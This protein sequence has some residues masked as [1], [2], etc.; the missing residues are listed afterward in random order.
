MSNRRRAI[1]GRLAAALWVLAQPALVLA[2]DAGHGGE[3]H[4]PSIADLTFPV[5]NFTIYLFIVFKYLVPALR[6]Y[7]R[8]RREDV[9]QLV[10][11]A[12][13]SLDEAKRALADARQALAAIATETTAIKSDIV[14][15]AETAAT[16]LRAQAEETGRRRV[17]DAQLLAEQERRRAIAELRAEIATLA[18]ATAEERIRGALSPNDHRAFVEQFLAEA[19]A[20]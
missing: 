16:R 19:P 13:A 20:R 3:H 10:A 11:G 4:V 9:E 5:I 6:E 17:A 8:R 1:L 7:L 18:T 2:S 14:A 15:A 12:T